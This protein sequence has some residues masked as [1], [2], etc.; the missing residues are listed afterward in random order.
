MKKSILLIIYLFILQ[1]FSQSTN[2]P[3]Y[4]KQELTN[5][6]VYT[7]PNFE[8]TT[9]YD[10]YNTVS[11]NGTI[12]GMFFE[13]LPYTNA[14]NGNND[15]KVF[16]WYGEP[17]GL[18]V[19][20]KVPAVILVHG[21]GGRA[22]TEWVAEWVNRGYIAIAMSNRGTTPD[23]SD[24]FQYAG[25][26]QPFFF[27]DND[28]LLQDQWFYHA[29]ANSMLSNSLLRNDSFTTHVDKNNIG[30]TGISWG[31]I[32]NTVIAGIDERLDFVIPV[33]GCGFL[34][35]SPVYSN[36]FSQMSTI[37]Q[38]FFLENWEPSLYAPLHTAPILYVNGN[39]D[40]QFT[41]NIFGKTYET[42]NSTE[43]FLRIEN[44][45]GHGHGAGRQPEE[46]YDFADYITGFNTNAV[47]PLEFTSE[48]I[49]NN[50][51]INY[52]YS[53]EGAVDE[54]LLFYTKDTLQWGKAD[55][56]Y[57]WLTQTTNLNKGV[58]SGVITTTLP[59]DA[60]AYYV[61]VNNTTDGLMYSSVI[62]YAIR[63]YDWYNYETDTFNTLI[64]NTSGGTLTEDTTN[65]NTSGIN[66]STYVGKFE[67]TLG[68]D[69]KI[70]FNLNENI[71]DISVFKQKIKLYISNADLSSIT[72]NK[73]RIY[74][75]NSEIDYKTSSLYEEAILNSGQSW[76]DYTFDFTTKT[77]P[78]DILYAG[79]FNQAILV[80]AP[81]DTT[82]SGTVYYYDDLRGTIDQPEYIAPEPYYN[83]LNYTEDIAVEEINYVSKVGGDYTKL[84]DISLD[85]DVTSSGSTSG[86]ATKFTKTTENSWQ[87]AQM[88]YDFED[89]AIK[90]TESIT[91]KLNA[92]FKPETISEINI[93]SDDSRSVSIYLQ[94][95]VGNTNLNQKFQKAYFTQTN[96]WETLEFTFTLS[97]LSAYDRL[98]IM[99]T[100]GLTYPIDE[101]G[102][103]LIN[104]DLIYYIESLTA[105][106]NIG[107]TL[108]IEDSFQPSE[109]LLVYPNP[110]KSILRINKTAKNT[111]ILNILGQKIQSFKN[112]NHFNVSH[113]KNGLYFL[114]VNIENQPTQVYRFIKK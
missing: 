29:I 15:T 33:Y 44:L 32:I 109:T 3:E 49:D 45:M 97:E 84:Y 90:D 73:V 8:F 5:S 14:A 52:S 74:L 62:K 70:V 46:I 72:N 35:N 57:L 85:T 1:V 113:L 27:S 86:I 65:P 37:A 19:N 55:D 9:A 96:V 71:T 59:D 4:I 23:D 24:T 54:A 41:L 10:S 40:L 99:P 7:S 34:Y 89:G 21:G 108:S 93:L 107:A 53:F 114:K 68:D 25:P 11:V 79:G 64:N 22:F 95:R 17:A 82:T 61:N 110:V 31:G 6:G 18:A 26:S 92:L 56:K 78:T 2:G 13:G 16:A 81:D 98:I 80:F 76:I 103:E 69:A 66:T 12:R 106:E 83:W 63:D 75:S 60:Q 36:Q 91:F 88:R 28:G 50:K 94:D 43:K 47:K 38:N 51:N 100:A 58:N 101:D 111:E 87:F 102:N 42:S 104:E 105:N 20:E 67:K 48:T 30:I 77:I 39:K 112:T